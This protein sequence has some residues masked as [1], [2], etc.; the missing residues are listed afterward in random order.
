MTWNEGC[1]TKE[2][3]REETPKFP[4]GFLRS[5]RKQLLIKGVSFGFI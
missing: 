4:G 2:Q 3:R 5:A 1:Q